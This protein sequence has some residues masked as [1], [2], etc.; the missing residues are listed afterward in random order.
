MLESPMNNMGFDAYHAAD[1]G[2]AEQTQKFIKVNISL[3][4]FS[5]QIQIYGVE[6]ISCY[7]FYVVLVCML[8]EMC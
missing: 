1:D 4:S 7:L 5:S 6:Y 2:S 3:I 8:C